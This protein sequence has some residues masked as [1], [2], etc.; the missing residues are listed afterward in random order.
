MGRPDAEPAAGM[1]QPR[2]CQAGSSVD[3]SSSLRYCCRQLPCGGA[4]SAAE[5][6]GLVGRG[7]GVTGTDSKRHALSVC[8]RVRQPVQLRLQHPAVDV[9][10]RPL[11]EARLDEVLAEALGVGGDPLLLGRARAA[12]HHLPRPRRRR[13]GEPHL[14]VKGPARH[15]GGVGCR[16]G[17]RHGSKPRVSSTALPCRGQGRVTRFAWCGTTRGPRRRSARSHRRRAARRR[18]P[19]GPRPPQ[20]LASEA[21]GPAPAQGSA[22]IGGVVGRRRSRSQHHIPH[23]NFAAGPDAEPKGRAG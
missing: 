12:K 18:L 23:V 19:R 15:K 9:V 4:A 2:R 21:D 8:E 5:P 7:M 17:R 13:D 10:P 1:I 16:P 3:R 14:A 20:R 6:G 11:P 22:R